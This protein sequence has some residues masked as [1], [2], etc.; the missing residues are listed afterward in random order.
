MREVRFRGR[1]LE[2][3]GWVHGDLVRQREE[4][5]IITHVDSM[6]LSFRYAEVDPTTVGQYTGLKDKNGMEIY[7]GD[8]VRCVERVG[9]VGYVAE[10]AS[11]LVF[12]TDEE[13]A[14]FRRLEGDGNLLETK[15]IGNIYDNPDV[16][17]P[18]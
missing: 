10:H 5:F 14:C 18:K 7:E 13:G 15:I 9:R 6:P 1:D 2:D 12:A 16:E 17:G 8:V 4:S 3:G 11:F